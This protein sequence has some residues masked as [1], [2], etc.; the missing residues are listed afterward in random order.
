MS[1]I[2]Y[3]AFRNQ[4]ELSGSNELVFCT[5]GGNPIGVQNVSN[6]V[7]KPLF[8]S[9]N[10]PYRRLYHTRHTAASLWLASGENV[11]WV[12][13]QLGHSD[14][15]TTLRK[16]AKHAPQRE[17]KKSCRDAPSETA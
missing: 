2:V 9:L 6:R 10:L 8:K 7:W 1:D 17:S 14:P 5:R 11:L 4:E 13:Q 15:N 12:S 16:H 3:D